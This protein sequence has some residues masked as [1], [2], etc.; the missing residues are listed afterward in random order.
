MAGEPQDLD[1]LIRQTIDP[2]QLMQR[3]GDQLVAMV[4][5]ADGA[6]V[7]LQID[8]QQLRFV[9]GSGHLAPQ[10]GNALPIEGSL[11][12]ET[13][14]SGQTRV[15]EDTES[16]GRVHKKTTRAWG[17]G[18]AVCVPLGRG[19]KSIGVLAVT[20]QRRRAF[21]SADLDLLSG[22]A[23][24]I[25]TT[26]AAA[27]DLM[28]ITARLCSRQPRELA[29][30]EEAERTNKF[31]ASVLDP[32]GLERVAAC[33]RIE[34]VLAERRFEIAFQ[35]IFDLRDGSVFA[36]EALARFAGEPYR[37]PDV[38]LAEAHASGLGVELEV[39]LLRAA[40]DQ[41]AELPANTVLTVNAGPEALAGADIGSLLAGVDASR[42]VVE[43]T[44]HAAVEDYPLLATALEG[45][46]AAGVR[47]AIDD[48]GAGFA[49]LMHI[50]RLAPDFIKLDR[51]LIH[52]LDKDPTKRSLA[53]SLMRFAEESGATI[54][55]EG[56]ETAA[57]LGALEQL[58]VLHAQGFYLGR[59][60]PLSE[61]G[62]MGR[63][64]RARVRRQGRGKPLAKP[65]VPHATAGRI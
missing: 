50:L 25:S 64:G 12:G 37:G 31:V 20:S 59:P 33:E 19:E 34:A 30:G 32:R 8:E 61:I 63:S 26:I 65:R 9:S 5:V 10:V 60:G 22:L 57:E 39:A 13:I 49:S 54:V 4:D 14:R 15:T 46:R 35:P 24:F 23:E 43:L 58:G 62:K 21:A 47:L 16:D 45:L 17:V 28:E 38:W 44:E 1:E 6:I 52:G 27:T 29:P 40:V 18:S 7:G 2:L 36:V 48:A 56:V 41:L 51:A 42:I 3:V 53:S 11:C 55:A